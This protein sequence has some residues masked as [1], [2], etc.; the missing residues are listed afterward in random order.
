VNRLRAR[1]WLALAILC[2]G[3]WSLAQCAKKTGPPQP[4]PGSVGIT[5]WLYTPPP[6]PAAPTPRPGRPTRT[7]TIS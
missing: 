5:P 3:F 2:A 1:E 7:P 4:R 6:A